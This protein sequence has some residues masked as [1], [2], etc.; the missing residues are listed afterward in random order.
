MAKSEKGSRRTS[1]QAQSLAAI[2][3]LGRV[4]APKQ[5]RSEQRLADIVHALHTLLHGRPFEDITIPA[6][7]A[8]AGCVPAS[9]YARFKDKRSILVALH[10][11]FREQQAA[12]IEESMSAEAHQKLSLEESMT[13]I[14]RNLARHYS[15]RHYMLRST[16]LLD[17]QEIYEGAGALIALMSS[18]VS[19]ILRH[20]LPKRQ[21][22]TDER[23]DLAVRAVFAL[24]QQRLIFRPAVVGRFAPS[25]ESEVTS[26][27]TTVFRSILGVGT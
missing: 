18:R 23:V 16:L 11:S 13:V 26:E 24:L 19:A 14:L 4:N 2:S 20:K 17:D 8:Q 6:I 12:R 15:R 27:I 21:M 1:A 7:A 10:E 9:I 5:A 3:K 22:P 25:D